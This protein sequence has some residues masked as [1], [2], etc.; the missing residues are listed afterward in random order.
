MPP[1]PGRGPRA[2]APMRARCPIGQPMMRKVLAS[3]PFQNRVQLGEHASIGGNTLLNYFV[4]VSTPRAEGSEMIKSQTWR[5]HLAAGLAVGL[6][7]AGLIGL[8]QPASADPVVFAPG[9]HPYGASYGEWSGRWWQWA[10]K[11]STPET[12]AVLDTTGA[13][14]ALRQ[15]GP[16]WFLAGLFD[17]GT[18]TRN[19]TVPAG[20]ALFFPVVSAFDANDPGKT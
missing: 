8:V 14:C 4:N 20:K 16:V 7:S 17:N 6:A 3:R 5:K 19:C 9:S 18:V 1:S 10:L 15:S 12:N 2:P 11:G 13:H